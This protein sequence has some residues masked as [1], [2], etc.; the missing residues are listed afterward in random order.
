[1]RLL[2]EGTGSLEYALTWK[3]W[4]MQSL[5]PICALRASGHRTSGNDSSGVQGWPSP[6]A[7]QFGHADLERLEKR[8]EECRAKKV[9]GN[10]FGLTLSQ[11]VALNLTGWPSPD[12]S[13]HGS[14]SDPEKALA[15]V[16]GKGNQK[17]NANLDDVAKLILSGWPSPTASLAD[18]GVRSEEGAIVEAAR[19]RGPDLAAVVSLTGWASP[20]NRDWRDGR[21]SQETMDRNARPLNEQAV[22]LA[23]PG[24]TSPSSH[25]GTANCVESLTLNPGF[26]RWLMGYRQDDLTHGWDTCSPDWQSWATVQQMLNEYS[27]KPEATGQSGCVATETQ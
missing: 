24:P 17:R 25:A 8:R 15:R 14:Y 2:L 1:L 20:A 9:N 3:E 7:E 19:N 26:S 13:R 11:A 22:M 6:T 23:I 21:A 16:S 5:V 27:R 12:A 10:G 4:G 18:K